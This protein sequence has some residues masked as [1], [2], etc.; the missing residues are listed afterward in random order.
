MSNET[1][2]KTP[3]VVKRR[4][5][6]IVGIKFD[7]PS[8]AASDNVSKTT[9]VAVYGPDNKQVVFVTD[10]LVTVPDR[11]KNSKVESLEIQYPG[12]GARGILLMALNGN[13]W[14]SVKPA[15]SSA[16]PTKKQQAEIIAKLEADAAAQA[17]ELEELKAQMAAMKKAT[18]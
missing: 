14:D 6:E 15:T 4:V 18:G 5:D 9:F 11:Y 13:L 17:D 12:I 2:I 7:L 10:S 16:G 8:A 3:I 1:E